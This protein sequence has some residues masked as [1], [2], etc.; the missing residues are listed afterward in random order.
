MDEGACCET[1]DRFGDAEAPVESKARLLTAKPDDVKIHVTRGGETSVHVPQ[2]ERVVF[3]RVSGND[4]VLPSGTISKRQLAVSFERN[5]VVVADLKSSCGTYVDG[6]KISAPTELREGS[7][8][9]AGDF[10]I[11]VTR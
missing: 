1:C 9:Y 3:G 11:R 2:G 7:V 10:Q 6:R 5:R 4:I 8:I